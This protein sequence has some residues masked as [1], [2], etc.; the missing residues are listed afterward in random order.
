[1]TDWRSLAHQT[2]LD[3]HQAIQVRAEKYP[4]VLGSI[5]AR[6]AEMFEY[7]VGYLRGHREAEDSVF[8]D[9]TRGVLDGLEE[10]STR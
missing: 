3:Q 8:A 7:L 2:V 1:M 5:E 4:S 9:I 10:L 6:K